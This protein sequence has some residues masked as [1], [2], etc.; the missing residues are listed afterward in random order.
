MTGVWLS[1]LRRVAWQGLIGAAV[2]SGLMAYSRR[3]VSASDQQWKAIFDQG[4]TM[5]FLVDPSGA[6][7]SVNGLAAQLGYAGDDLIGRPWLDLS[8]AADRALDESHLARCLE[9]SASS[10]SWEARKLRGDGTAI[11]T[12]QNARLVRWD[13]KEPVFLVSCED[14]TQ[15]RKARIDAQEAVTRSQAYLLEAQR[16]GQIG[17]WSVDV[18]TNVWTTSPELLRILDLERG[19][20]LTADLV[21]QRAHPEDRAFI[22]SVI[23]GRRSSASDYEY[24]YRIVLPSGETR[25]L[26]SVAHP[27]LDEDGALVEYVGTTMDVTERRQAD[28]QLRRSEAS[29][30]DAQ[31]IGRMGS[32]TQDAAT[33]VMSATPE[34]YRIFGLDPRTDELTRDGLGR[35]IHPDDLPEVGATIARGR[36]S[37]TIIE[38]DHRIVR[39]DGAIRHVHGVSHPVFTEGGE[40]GE[41]IGTVMDV[42][43]IRQAE[44][45][46]RQAYADL[47]RASRLTI[48]GELTA[49]LAHEVNQPIA[50][51]VANAN[52]A[53]RFLGAER[54]DLDEARAAVEAIIK[55]STRAAQIVSRTRRLFEKGAPQRELIA[56]DDVVR[57]TVLLLGGEALRHAVAIRTSAADAP[58]I[59]ADRVQLQQVLM[60]LILNGIDAVKEV[61]GRREVAIQSRIAD[62]DQIVVSVSDTGVGL[63]SDQADRLFE[64]FFTTKAH[65]T[66]LGLSISRSIIDGHGGRLW[67]EPN[68]PKGA[69]FHFT[70]PLTSTQDPAPLGR[71]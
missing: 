9:D 61:E 53:L 27:V 63:P 59:F 5:G 10:Q 38:V 6:I 35:M 71:A 45:A 16:L 44:E 28:D 32:W 30:H 46:L 17:S 58:P 57:E 56:V 64:T 19:A 49:A 39:P 42:T 13:D 37:D 40:L 34:L 2:V 15:R 24:D 52:A 51:A 7:L 66:G 25:H 21:L 43:E 12:R 54:P 50:A 4:P 68:D 41:W 48:I 1:R 69:V 62:G 60:N 23:E 11:W 3:R 47:A 31:R 67:A 14:I 22:A 55:S 36:D 70:L 65:G 29:L 8:F 26:H 18:A 33:G 20:E